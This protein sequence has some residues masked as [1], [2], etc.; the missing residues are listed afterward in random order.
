MGIQSAKQNVHWKSPLFEVVITS[1]ND[2]CYSQTL[3]RRDQLAITRDTPA[4]NIN[5]QSVINFSSLS[6]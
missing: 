3:H 6:F 4:L 2:L 1:T 5:E